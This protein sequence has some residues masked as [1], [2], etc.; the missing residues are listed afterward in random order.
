MG[1]VTVGLARKRLSNV[2]GFIGELYGHDL[3]A[4]RAEAAA[5]AAGIP[6]PRRWA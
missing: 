5:V 1:M 2:Q 4:K 6:M 3:H